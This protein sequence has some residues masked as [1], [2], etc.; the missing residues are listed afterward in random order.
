MSNGAGSQYLEV[1]YDKFVFQVRQG[2][3]YTRDDLWLRAEDSGYRIGL[4][5]FAQRVAGD[6]AFAKLASAGATLA[7]SETLAEIETIKTTLIV[8]APMDGTVLEVNEALTDYPEK[9]NTDPYGEGWLA[10]LKPAE[11]MPVFLDALAY[12]DLMR[13]KLAEEDRKR[14]SKA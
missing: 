9:I 12:M 2:D 7:R 8:G 14:Q 13:Q 10:M 6:A 4:T 5:D 1:I 3:M 11:S